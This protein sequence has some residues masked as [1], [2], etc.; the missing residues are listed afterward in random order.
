MRFTHH[1]VDRLCNDFLE[2]NR[3][4]KCVGCRLNDELKKPV[5]KRSTTFL[6]KIEGRVRKLRHAPV[7]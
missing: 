1:D 5:A 6:K 4:G 7:V 2:Q 3:T